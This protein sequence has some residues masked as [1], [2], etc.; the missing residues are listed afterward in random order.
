MSGFPDLSLPQQVQKALDTL[1][2]EEQ[3][4]M[5]A[6]LEVRSIQEVADLLGIPYANVIEIEKRAFKM[7][8][9]TAQKMKD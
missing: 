6:R 8:K 5:R 9:E 2:D 1:P 4:V 7:L 3:K